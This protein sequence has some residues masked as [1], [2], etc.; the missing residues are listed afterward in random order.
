[1]RVFRARNTW[2]VANWG[3]GGT[4]MLPEDGQVWDIDEPEHLFVVSQRLHETMTP[5]Y[6]FPKPRTPLNA[7][8][9]FFS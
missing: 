4:F 7:P 2:W 5:W 9:S 1:M 3:E 8:P 6:K